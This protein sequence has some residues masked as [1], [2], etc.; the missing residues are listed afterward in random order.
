MCGPDQDPRKV[1]HTGVS[2]LARATGVTGVETNSQVR[3]PWM[4]PRERGNGETREASLCKTP[5]Y[6]T[7]N[8][9]YT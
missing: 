9:P 7:S 6:L 3:K 2:M 1:H 5:Q 8:I 4:R